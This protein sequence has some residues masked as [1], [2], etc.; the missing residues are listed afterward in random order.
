MTRPQPAKRRKQDDETPRPKNRKKKVRKKARVERNED[1]A[2]P[3]PLADTAPTQ[4]LPLQQ[5][6]ELLPPVCRFRRG[7]QGLHKWGE[8]R[9]LRKNEAIDA[10]STTVD[11]ADLIELSTQHSQVSRTSRISRAGDT[12]M[13][14]AAKKDLPAGEA[15]EF[16]RAAYKAA[17]KAHDD[18][19]ARLA[20]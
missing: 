3:A 11:Y 2:Q 8:R 17:G 9:R 12:T 1:P 20:R 13:R 19:R 4:S 10:I 5:T 6:D 15:K 18:E 14:R 16:A 7:G